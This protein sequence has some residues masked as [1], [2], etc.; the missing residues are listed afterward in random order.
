[1]SKKGYQRK[2]KII[3]ANT[4]R[5]DRPFEILGLLNFCG[6]QSGVKRTSSSNILVVLI[7]LIFNYL[8]QFKETREFK[9]DKSSSSSI[10]RFSRIH[11]YFQN[12][13]YVEDSFHIVGPE[14]ES[15]IATIDVSTVNIPNSYIGI[16]VR[17]GDNLFTLETMGS[18]SSNYYKSILLKINKIKSLPV[19]IFTDDLKGASDVIEIVSPDFVFGPEDLSVWQSLKLMSNSEYLITAN[20]TFSWWAAILGFK[21]NRTKKVFIPDPWFRNWEKPIL[22]AF[23]FPG[24]NVETSDFIKEDKFLTDYRIL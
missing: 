18:L 1:M 15:Y 21:T 13:K 24:F 22:D 17:R 10:T 6:H 8:F 23:Q 5:K 4:S 7:R 2:I 19:V 3:S 16:H 12:W 9:F 11:G 20:S 14:I